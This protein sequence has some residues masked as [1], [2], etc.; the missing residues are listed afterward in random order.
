MV[1]FDP[2]YIIKHLN[3]RFPNDIKPMLYG[4]YLLPLYF[5]NYK[6]KIVGSFVDE[7]QNDIPYPDDL[8]QD[9]HRWKT[10][11][12]IKEIGLRHWRPDVRG[13]LIVISLLLATVHALLKSPS[14]VSS[15][16]SRI[17]RKDVASVRA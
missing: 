13:L 17:S 8:P 5:R 7:Y 2:I 9:V 16:F 1:H 6:G 3:D 15:A 4:F 11:T 10:L 14:N 12:S